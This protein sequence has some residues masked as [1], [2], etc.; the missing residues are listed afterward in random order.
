MKSR[1][2]VLA[3]AAALLVGFGAPNA[4]T[5][6]LTGHLSPAIAG[7]KL[8]RPAAA[9]RV[10]GLEVVLALH[11]RAALDQLIADQQNPSSPEY[12]HALAPHKTGRHFSFGI[13]STKNSVSKKPVVSV[14][15][16]GRPIWLTT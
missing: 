4:Q 5:V 7:A 12:R 10:M 16:S 14:P 3:A 9:D 6:K 15:S 8:S 1:V 13:R 2:A 11:N